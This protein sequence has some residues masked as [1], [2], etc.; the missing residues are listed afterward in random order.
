MKIVTDTHWSI[1]C[2]D[3]IISRW[4][5]VLLGGD[6]NV[7]FIIHS[8]RR[9]WKCIFHHSFSLSFTLT[10]TSL[11]RIS[12]LRQQV[13]LTLDPTSQCD[14]PPSVGPLRVQSGNFQSWKQT[15]RL[16]SQGGNNGDGQVLIVSWKPGHLDIFLWLAAVACPASAIPR[17]G[18]PPCPLSPDFPNAEF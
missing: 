1:S 12:S 10:L 2:V 6:E 13:C 7:Y 8:L 3:T 16:R 4:W 11:A 18:C 9:R 14:P 17:S 5:L 15:S